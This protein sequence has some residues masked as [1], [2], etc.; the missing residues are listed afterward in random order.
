MPFYLSSEGY[1]FLWNLASFGAVDLRNDT[2]RW[3]ST[4]SALV[5]VWVTVAPQDAQNHFHSL[6]THFAAAT[7][8]PP[9]MPYWAT[10]LWHSKNRYRS[11]AELLQAARHY[12]AL[13]IPLSVIAIDFLHWKHFGDF[14]FD[15]ACWPDPRAMVRVLLPH[16]FFFSWALCISRGGE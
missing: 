6:M 2:I 15:E 1:A 11:Q 4:G 9:L 14:A 7:G 3:Q 13:H 5:D 12:H 10:G 16:Q 8:G